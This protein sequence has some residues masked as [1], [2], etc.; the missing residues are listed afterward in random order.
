M[1]VDTVEETFRPDGEKVRVAYLV[2]NNAQRSQHPLAIVNAKC[3]QKVRLRFS[4]S[5]PLSAA[6]QWRKLPCRSSS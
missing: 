4:L 3:P 1:S 6:G 2:W 5:L